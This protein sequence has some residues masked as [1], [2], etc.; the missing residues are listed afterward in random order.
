MKLLSL[1]PTIRAFAQLPVAALAMVLFLSLP[2]ASNAQETSSA[3]RGTVTDANGAPIAGAEVIVKNEDTGLTRSATTSSAGDYNVRNLPIA[4]NY[5]ASV[6]AEGYAGARTEGVQIN[7]GRTAQENFALDAAAAIEEIIVTGTQSVLTQTAVGPSASFGLEELESAPAINRNIVDV[8]RADPRIYVDESQGSINAVQCAGKSPRF[9]SLTVDGVRMNDGFG[10]NDNGY[11]TERMP[12]SY[13]AIEQVSVELAPFDVEYGGFSACNINSVTKSGGNSFSGS[14]FYD[15]TDNDL[16]ADS[17]EGDS[18]STVA[19]EDKRYGITFGGPV[20]QDRLFFFAAYEKLE[21]AN[22]FD[23]GPVGSGA[24][25]EINVTQA[26]LERIR[27]IAIREYQYDPGGIPSSIPH[28]DEK[29][30]VKLD[31]NINDRQ[32]MAFTYNWND[33]E[34]FRESDGDQNEFEFQNHLYERGAELTSYTGVLYSDWTDN[35]STQVRASYL[36]LDNRQISIDGLQFGEM[37]ITAPA[38]DPS[39]PA[40]IVYL[41]S[42]DS[43][44]ANQMSYDVTSLKFKGNYYRGD[45]VYT[46]GVERE[47]ID[48][49]NVF[50]QHVLTETRFSSIDDFENGFANALYHNNAPSGDPADA[51]AVW[52]YSINT[53]YGQDEVQISD[54]LSLVYGLRYDWYTSSDAPGE[55]PD[56]VADYG[57]SNS[58]NLDGEGLL[59]PRFGFTFDW[60]GDTTIHGGVGLYS[61]GDPNVWLSNNFSN[62]NVLQFGTRGRRYCYTPRLDRAVIDCG[63]VQRSLFDADIQYVQIYG[64]DSGGT[65]IGP[66]YGVPSELVADVA[67]GSGD[68]FELNYLD[69]NFKLP[70]EWK[71]NIGINHTFPGD[72]MVAA[73]LLF[74]RGFDSPMVKRGD[75]VRTGTNADGYPVYSS[76]VLDSFVLTN[77]EEGNNFYYRVGYSNTDAEDVQPMT[78]AVAFSNY[79]FRAFFDPNEDV[80]STSNYE[81]EHRFAATARWTRDIGPTT[82]T[83]SLYGSANSGRPFS[84][85]VLGNPIYNFNPFLEDT[86]VNVLEP[87]DKRNEN[88]GSWWRKVDM[89]VNLDFPGFGDGH[90]ASAFLVIDNLTNLLND[91]W[92]VLKQHNFPYSV[93]RGTNEP[94][95]GDASRYEI[96]FGV[97]YRFE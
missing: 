48:I 29:I 94:R 9:N 7:L 79:N 53:L 61:G 63:G 41:G 60:T 91:E 93:P 44:Q 77:S 45:H 83:V 66:G 62:N 16:R 11:P 5:S 58:T 13:D 65:A 38:A 84:Y 22:L 1:R 19:Y 46:F 32:R 30:L 49:F 70:N 50:I 12:F 27:Q 2:V 96:R 59:Q 8:L 80:L 97:Q 64:P 75:L 72:Y 73:D 71:F 6:E 35:F 54:R 10:L 20:L 3:V 47:D 4:T 43:R 85:A 34:N 26:D 15:Y 33:G 25:N 17:L 82:L 55:N 86:I 90:Y 36:E 37:Q 69:P 95:I 67:A 92:G 74:T 28:E 88:T 31:L 78:S 42:D 40:V 56:F 89:R 87:G 81:I 18:I 68:N 21:G 23:R 76:P 52:G 24:V 51:A 57:F 39:Q 14:A